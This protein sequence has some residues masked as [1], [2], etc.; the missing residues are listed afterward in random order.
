ML[1]RGVVVPSTCI[2]AEACGY[3]VGILDY[4][5]DQVEP[6][7]MKGPTPSSCFLVPCVVPCCEHSYGKIILNVRL[8]F[9][10]GISVRKFFF[11]EGSLL[12]N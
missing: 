9:L 4:V 2:S 5:G 10:K 11:L 1:V 8:I 3:T 6:W 7:R 12:L